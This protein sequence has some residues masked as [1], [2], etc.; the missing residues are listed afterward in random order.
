MKFN[1]SETKLLQVICNTSFDSL[2][3]V[4]K[5]VLLLFA[6]NFIESE[7]IEDSTNLLIF[8]LASRPFK[9]NSYLQ[10][11]FLGLHISTFF[12]FYIFMHPWVFRAGF[13]YN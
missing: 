1:I 11:V 4:L 13:M 2:P 6:L 9:L 7:K 10:L 8:I 3:T 5:R 12:F